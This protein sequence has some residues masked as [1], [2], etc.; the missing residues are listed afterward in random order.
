MVSA[1][2]TRIV[3]QDVI[4][5]VLQPLIKIIVVVVYKHMLESNNFFGCKMDGVMESDVDLLAPQD[6]LQTILPIPMYVLN[7][8]TSVKPAQP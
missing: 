4:V 3:I 6:I 5:D 7:V 8:P 2:S 1:K